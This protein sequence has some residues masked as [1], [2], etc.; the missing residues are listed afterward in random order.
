MLPPARD[1]RASSRG[2]TA[3]PLRPATWWMWCRRARG[4]RRETEVPRAD[5]VAEQIEDPAQP[6]LDLR[7][8]LPGG[9]TDQRVE[10]RAVRGTR[11]ELLLEAS[12]SPRQRQPLDEQEVL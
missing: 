3:R 9:A 2:L 4:W 11:R 12:R 8:S 6:A 7:Q 1:G 5:P 10:L